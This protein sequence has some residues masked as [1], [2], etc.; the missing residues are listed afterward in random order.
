MDS[1]DEEVLLESCC[2]LLNYYQEVIKRKRK[3]TWM[4]DIFK[5]R[6]EQRGCHKLLQK[7]VSTIGNRIS[8][9]L[10]NELFSKSNKE[11][12]TTF[13]SM[14][15]SLIFHKNTIK[16]WS[17]AL[18]AFSF[19]SLSLY[20]LFYFH[21]GKDTSAIPKPSVPRLVYVFLI[22]FVFINALIIFTEAKI[23]L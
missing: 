9:Y 11:K 19:W 8:G 23:F 21:K 7:V 18:Q 3:R 12:C 14:A 5:K 20:P 10:R 1:S 16:N 6:I 4:W 15:W 2:F 13:Q 22:F 17:T